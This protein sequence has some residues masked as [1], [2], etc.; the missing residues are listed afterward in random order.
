MNDTP[1]A[2]TGPR[3]PWGS[4]PKDNSAPETEVVLS[5]TIATPKALV[6]DKAEVAQARF[7]LLKKT[8]SGLVTVIAQMHLEEDW[9]HL[10]RED[11]TSYKNLTEVVAEALSVG[12]AMARRYIQG[13]KDLYLP[14]EAITIEGTIISIDS[15][16]VRALGSEGAKEV[17]QLA[18]ER[19]QGV[20]DPE[21]ASEIV[22]DTIKEVREKPDPDASTKDESGSFYDDDGV[23][24]DPEV[25]E[26]KPACGKV[27]EDSDD[28]CFFQTQHIGPCSWDVSETPAAPP[29]SVSAIDDPI[30]EIIGTGKNYLDAA[31]RATLPPELQE[32]VAALATVAALDPAKVA[33]LVKYETRGIA[34]LL[35]SASQNAARMQ[36]VIECQPWLLARLT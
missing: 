26:G 4:S 17:I 10:V 33:A 24:F 25:M 34:R 3:N 23:T 15:S 35:P 16:D 2:E 8:F 28:V 20:D 11:G 19:L 27:S 1:R 13:A 21:E 12:S 30:S 9:K 32:V 18:E 7:Q 36:T 6:A 14:L 31:E 5:G 29:V 22:K